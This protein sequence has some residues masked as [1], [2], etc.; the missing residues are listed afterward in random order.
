[1]IIFRVGQSLHSLYAGLFIFIDP[2]CRGRLAV[3]FIIIELAEQAIG[4]M[5]RGVVSW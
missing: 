1:M 5:T 3:Q 4:T 2:D